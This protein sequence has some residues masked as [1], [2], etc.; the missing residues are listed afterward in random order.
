MAAELSLKVSA[1]PRHVARDHVAHFVHHCVVTTATCA[2]LARE[3][4]DLGRTE[5][6]EVAIQGPRGH[7]ASSTMP[8]KS[9]PVQCE[10]IV[11]MA[12]TVS[13]LSSAVYRAMEAGHERSAGEWQIEWHLIPQ[14][15]ALAGGCLLLASEV[16]DRLAVN[17]KRMAENLDLDHGLL[18]AE[19][20]MFALS[21]LLG[22]AGAH[23]VVSDAAIRVRAGSGGLRDLLAGVA[24]PDI[25]IPGSATVEAALG[26]SV[27][28]AHR[29]VEL[30]SNSP[31]DGVPS[32]H[33]QGAS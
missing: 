17:E 1:G 10:A 4:I 18:F 6:G 21:P 16:L 33:Q 23:D 7:G 8:Q 13:A 5:I 25:V 24:P 19:S 3:V 26:T 20:T 14:V 28:D 15:A 11:G 32:N 30:W 9:N 2:R 22:R 31:R 12:G 29:A 27:S